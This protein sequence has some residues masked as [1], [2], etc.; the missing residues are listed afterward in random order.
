MN[1]SQSPR[2][3]NFCEQCGQALSSDAAFC[4][5]C[6]R[7][8]R[9]DERGRETESPSTRTVAVKSSSDTFI[10][11]LV[12]FVI[13]V[14]VAFFAVWGIRTKQSNDRKAKQEEI[15]ACVKIVELG[16]G[17][18]DAVRECRRDYG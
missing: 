3:A 16:A 4:S 8:V 6:G 7:P 18:A 5:S 17:H 13:A 10:K 2:S 1:E 9:A 15:Q 14:V 12:C 11:V